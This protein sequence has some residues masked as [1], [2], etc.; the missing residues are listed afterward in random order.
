MVNCH[1][2]LGPQG[3]V[4]VDAGLP[5]SQAKVHRVLRRH[6][7][8]YAD[9]KLIVITHAHIDHAGSARKLRELSGAPIVAH[10]GDLDYYEQR[11]PMTFCTTD[12]FSRQFFRTGVIRRPYA[13]FTPDVLLQD[14]E[15]LDLRPYGLAGRVQHTPGHTAGSISVQMAGGEAMVGDLLASGVM[16]GGLVGAMFHAGSWMWAN[17]GDQPVIERHRV[18]CTPYGAF[19]DI[20]F[21]GD[22]QRGRWTDVKRCSL[23]PVMNEVSCDKRCLR[24]INDAGVRPGQGCDCGA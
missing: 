3:C 19:A 21:E 15:S 7:L 24:R 6:G 18:M 4:L 11:K 8:D 13:P 20:D 23:L 17:S 1:L 9:I 2:L 12:W 5:G 10:A 16:L 22:R 14:G